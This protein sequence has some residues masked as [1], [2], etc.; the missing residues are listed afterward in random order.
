VADDLLVAW[1]SLDA[2]TRDALTGHLVAVVAAKLSELTSPLGSAPH[3]PR[4]EVFAAE[5]DDPRLVVR[6]VADQLVAGA[7]SGAAHYIYVGKAMLAGG[8]LVE[9]TVVLVKH[10]QLTKSETESYDCAAAV[11]SLRDPVVARLRGM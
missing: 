11:A 6:F 4:V 2:S 10:I 9:S 3:R 5:H 8:A 7:Q 1:R